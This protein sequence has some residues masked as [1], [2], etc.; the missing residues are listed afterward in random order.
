LP[1]KKG[2]V[3]L[4]VGTRKGVFIFT[5]DQRRKEWRVSGPH[6]KGNEIYHAAYD[7]RSGAI[8]AS[9]NSGNWGPT[10]SRSDDMGKTWKEAK[11]PPRFPKGSGLSVARVW[12]IRPGSD[13]EPG[14]VYA[15]VE[16][17]CL[18][19]SGDGGR[20]WRVNESLMNQ[21]TRKKWQPGAGGLCL[22]TILINSK[23]PKRMHV[24]ISAVG[25][26]RTDD[27]GES[28]R[29]QN[30]NVLA[31]FQPEKYPVYGQCVH[32]LAS[33]PST[34]DVIFHQNHCGVYRSDDGGENWRDIRSNLPSRFGFPMAVDAN[35]PK[36]A[37]VA[38]MEG[39]FSRIPPGGHFAVWGTDNAG[40][41]WFKLD[42]GLPAV[43]YY[44][45]LRDGMVADMEDPCGLYFGTT[46]G[47]LYASRDQGNRWQNISDGLPPVLSVSV[48]GI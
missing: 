4:L 28:W 25:T 32:K 3:C 48:S 29:F 21:K 35:E 33:N 24:A 34:P 13:D 17:A 20:S 37:Y 15:G 5:S 40:K 10:V 30:K 31:D 27:G 45:V 12:Q 9:V 7:G 11:T 2:R 23:K 26:M 46:T 43:S 44:T 18:F 38:P 1:S 41:E 14:V 47:Q 6:F 22:H 42:S 39:D 8:F 36:R 16:P 19:R